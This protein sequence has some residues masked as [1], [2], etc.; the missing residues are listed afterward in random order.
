[1]ASD[2]PEKEGVRERKRRETHQR[3]A[4][5]G[6]RLFVAHGYDA[7]TL[8]AIAAAAGISRRTFFY[9]FKSKDDVL[10]SVQSTGSELLLSILRQ[11]PPGLAPI[12]AVR[13]AMLKV[14][15]PYQSD[16][17]IIIYRLLRSNETLQAR[18][19]AGF[20]EKERALF[21]TLCEMWPQPERRTALRLVAMASMGAFRLAIDTWSAEGG[22]R[23]LVDMLEEAFAALKAE[24]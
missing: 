1:M 15:P 20:V 14:I 4:E 9:Y 5:A 16:E 17:L 2:L 11:Q 18:K 10:L 7:T 23:P 12:D 8:E 22:K 21:A 13:N 24:I 6:M 19:Q 3:I